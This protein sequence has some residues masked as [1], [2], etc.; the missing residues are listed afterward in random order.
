MRLFSFFLLVLLY[1]GI[2]VIIYQQPVNPDTWYHIRAGEAY[3]HYG[4]LHKDIFSYVAQ[5]RPWFP[6]EWLFE[7]ILYEVVHIFGLSI[8]SIFTIVCTLIQLSILYIFIYKF[9]HLQRI[10][11]ICILFFYAAWD[12]EFFVAR[13]YLLATSYFI[14][15]ILFIFLFLKTQKKLWLFFSIPITLLWANMH[16]SVVFAVYLYLSY[17]VLYLFKK[18][19]PIAYALSI[20]GVINFLLTILPPINFS[21]YQ[22]LYLFS[23]YSKITTYFP[24]WMP[25]YELFPQFSVYLISLFFICIPLFFF[26]PKK[27]S[28]IIVF[29]PLSI[30]LLLPFLAVRNIFFTHIVMVI[31]AAWILKQLEPFYRR[32][33]FT[34]I[35]IGIFIAHS[36]LLYQ[37][38][39]ISIIYPKNAVIFLQHHF[40]KGRMFNTFTSG[41]YLMY[42]LYPKYKVFIDLRTEVY[43]CCELPA[44]QN[45]EKKSTEPYNLYKKDVIDYFNKYNFSF[46]LVD[47]HF[48]NY[49]ALVGKTLEN[50]PQ[51][52]LIYFDDVSEIFVKRNGFNDKIIKQFEV[53]AAT[54]Y[55]NTPYRKGQEELALQEY[56]RMVTIV[57]SAKSENAI[58]L[59]SLQKRQS[60][61]AEKY[62]R[63]A[64]LLNPTFVPPYLNL[65][66]IDIQQK[67]YEQA[68][69]LYEDVLRIDPTSP[70][71]YIYLGEILAE[72]DHDLPSAR[73]IWSRGVQNIQD[74]NAQT[75]LQ[76]LL[77]Q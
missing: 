31:I 61:I 3:L 19:L 2:S 42:S 39:S 28:E 27:R 12:M 58:G 70:Q 60:T 75:K 33:W 64:L 1:I 66:A 45:L 68:K 57:D 74:K 30:F 34:V 63:K 72:V 17:A 9:F 69:V 43:A 55:S 40:I 76:L 65:A 20:T 4:I 29:L 13:P 77:N 22:L 6:Q 56:Q 59:I 16:A 25:V 46:A 41:S 26:L 53:K 18:N 15:T 73:D 52:A 37:K 50:E 8:I 49:T 23:G 32:I 24:E 14:L 47:Y 54:P 7:V 38:S 51:W 11:A 44:Y 10:Y 36:W 21:Q 71:P 67:N 5:G 48:E 35:F 62:F